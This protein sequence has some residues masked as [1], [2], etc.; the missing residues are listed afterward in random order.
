MGAELICVTLK[1][2]CAH[3]PVPTLNNVRNVRIQQKQGNL[4]FKLVSGMYFP[5]SRQNDVHR[6]GVQE[7]A[8]MSWFGRRFITFC[9]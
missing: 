9:I 1:N 4:S 2:I 6:L 5:T 8:A 7:T 3:S